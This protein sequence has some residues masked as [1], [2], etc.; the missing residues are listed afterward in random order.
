MYMGRVSPGA[1]R[2]SAGSKSE[3]R[4]R[5]ALSG[6]GCGPGQGRPVTPRGRV[7]ASTTRLDAFARKAPYVSD[8]TSAGSE[9]GLDQKAIV[10]GHHAQLAQR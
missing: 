10:G 1:N 6:R 5:Y 8:G 9:D 2:R 7:G 4:V 3:S